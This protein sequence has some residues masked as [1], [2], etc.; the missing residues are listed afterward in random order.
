MKRQAI[1]PL[2]I[3]AAICSGC[4]RTSYINL[5]PRVE[6]PAHTSD[7][8]DRSQPKLWRNFWVWGWAPGEMA[9][10]AQKACGGI[11][12]IE[13]I[14]TRETFVQGLIATFA[15]YYINIYSPYTGGVVCD[16]SAGR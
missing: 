4:F 13:R 1:L 15:G 11:E 16:H 2:L 6:A 8:L 10:D 9:I 7:E 3:V 12:H 14:K 5:H